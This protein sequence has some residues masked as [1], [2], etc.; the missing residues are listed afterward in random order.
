MAYGVSLGWGHRYLLRNGW[1][2]VSVILEITSPGANQKIEISA[3]IFIFGF[4]HLKHRRPARF[5]ASF[6][7]AFCPLVRYLPILLKRCVSTANGRMPAERCTV[8]IGYPRLMGGSRLEDYRMNWQGARRR[9]ILR[10]EYH[11]AN[12]A[13]P[14]GRSILLGRIPADGWV[15]RSFSGKYTIHRVLRWVSNSIG[16]TPAIGGYP[17]Q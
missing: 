4:P 13:I 16:F 5:Y 12:R 11:A 17:I 14:A 7:F 1:C 2:A 8:W 10:G 9:S 6:R 3:N 15:Y